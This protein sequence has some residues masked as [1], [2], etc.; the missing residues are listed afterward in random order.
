M[1]RSPNH[2]K[3]YDGE[4]FWSSIKQSILSMDGKGTRVEKPTEG[5]RREGEGSNMKAWT[6]G[7]LPLS[8]E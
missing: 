4:K 6:R 5:G 2:A 7:L 1:G 3:S 8:Y